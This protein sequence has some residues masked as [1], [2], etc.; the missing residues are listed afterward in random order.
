[1]EIRL[2][3]YFLK[4]AE[5][6][7]MT[8]AAAD[9]HI[10]QPTLSRQIHAFEERL[11]T[12][13]FIRDNKKLTLTDS[14]R[15]LKAKAEELVALDQKTEQEFATY[16]DQELTGK[17][18]IGCIES[19]NSTFLAQIMKKMREK[20]NQVTF[21]IYSG[22]GIDILEKLE[23]GLV[24][25]A[26]MVG[27]F[28]PDMSAFQMVELPGKETL[29]IIV[30]EESPLSQNSMVTATDVLPLPIIGAIR[31]EVQE[32][33]YQ[34][35][36][37]DPADINLIGTYNMLFNV[38]P[39]VREGVGVAFAIKGGSSSDAI[40]TKFIPLNP[41][42][43]SER[44]LAWKKDRILNPTAQEFVQLATHASKAGKEA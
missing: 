6:Q 30:A 29:G 40:G 33:L 5:K 38:L 19:E 1:M 35:G 4:V 24:D 39:M 22:N 20:H 37:F 28:K 34:W 21:E 23:D 7:N 31:P 17:I 3:Q 9:L 16:Q 27:P 36:N 25:L 13:L 2:L 42:L 8:Q 15:F 26:F 18:T 10:T 11:Q 12:N 43:E 32:Q 44:V 41:I 14:G